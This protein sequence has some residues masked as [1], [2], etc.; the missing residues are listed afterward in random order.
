MITGRE[1]RKYGCTRKTG[2][3]IANR[4]RGSIKGHEKKVDDYGNYA[5]S[6]RSGF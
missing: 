2:S 4:K 5:D 6:K 3:V 1:K